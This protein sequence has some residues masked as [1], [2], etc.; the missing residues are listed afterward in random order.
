MKLLHLLLSVFAAST[1]MAC[2]SLSN[3]TDQGTSTDLV[4]PDIEKSKFNHD[5]SQFGSWPNWDNV[6]TIEK[7]MNKDQISNLLGVPH[8][9]EGLF[10]VHEWDYVFNYNENG[11]HRICQYKILFD[12]NMDAQSFFW[13]PNGCNSQISFNLKSDFLFD[14]DKSDL[15]P[16]S[17]DVIKDI[18]TKLKAAS[19]KNVRIEGHTDLLGTEEYNLRL[20]QRRADTVK[21]QLMLEGVQ[22]NYMAVGLGEAKQVKICENERGQSLKDCLS[23]NRRVLILVEDEIKRT[24]RTNEAGPIGPSLLYTN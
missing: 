23:P 9:S 12:K 10:N 17:L 14:F 15:K 13:Y 5:G 1:L 22:A 11:V 20:S 2:G 24:N 16:G 18:A 21:K 3:I 7:G 19:V 6:R 8:F 4:W